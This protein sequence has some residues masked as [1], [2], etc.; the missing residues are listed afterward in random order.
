MRHR[1]FAR[2]ARL[3]GG[4]VARARGHLEMVWEVAYEN[5]DE[6]LG[7]AGDVEQLAAWRGKPGQLVDALV[8]AGFLDA[9]PEGLRVHDLWD[10]APDYV[11]KRRSRES[12][13][14]TKGAELARPADSDRT[15]TGH[16]PTNGRTRAPAPAPAPTQEALSPRASA[17][18]RDQDEKQAETKSAASPGTVGPE[19]GSTAAA[20]LD[21]TPAPVGHPTEGATSTAAEQAARDTARAIGA[22]HRLRALADADLDAQLPRTAALLAWLREHQVPLDHAAK[23]AGRKAIEQALDG[24][25]L[26]AVGPRVAEAWRRSPRGTLGWFMHEIAPALDRPRASSAADIRFGVAP[27]APH[28]AFPEDTYRAIE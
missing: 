18:A 21:P 25:A 5:G 4:D 24:Q 27:P 28:T 12:Q 14:R 11:R 19:G 2:L 10:H 13:R 15:V 1:K 26:D 9:S 3:L 8:Q 16:R 20:R 23:G 7:D 17:P 22:D 6:L